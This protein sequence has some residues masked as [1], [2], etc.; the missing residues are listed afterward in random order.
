MSRNVF[1][2]CVMVEG[3]IYADILQSHHF[4][5]RTN[6]WLHSC[7]ITLT[8]GAHARHPPLRPV[9]KPLK[10]FL[11]MGGWISHLGLK[12]KH[13]LHHHHIKPPRHS[14]IHSFISQDIPQPSSFPPRPPEFLF[15]HR[16]VI[17]GGQQILSQ[18]LE[19]RF[20]FL[21]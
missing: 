2:D 5:R 4:Q 15:Y 21:P 12:Q 18:V 11:Q 16:K 10:G 1:C 7:P 9:V 6:D 20:L 19:S 13:R 17:V 3:N 8:F 14:N